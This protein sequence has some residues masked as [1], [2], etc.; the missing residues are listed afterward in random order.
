MYFIIC[1]AEISNSNSFYATVR[2]R[3]RKCTTTPVLRAA[4][5]VVHDI[6]SSKEQIEHSTHALL[7]N[8]PPGKMEMV[9]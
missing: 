1:F 3:E 2:E 6:P 7:D 4:V 8:D 5:V 9:G